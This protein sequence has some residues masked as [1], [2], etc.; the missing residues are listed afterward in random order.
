VGV[1][2]VSCRRIISAEY[3]RSVRR[4]EYL[5]LESEKPL[6][7]KVTILRIFLDVL[8]IGEED[9]CALGLF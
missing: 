6:T 4:V 5:F 9:F 2:L 1:I 7:F 8:V 3:E